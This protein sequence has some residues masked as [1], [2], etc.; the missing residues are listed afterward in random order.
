MSFNIRTLAAAAFALASRAGIGANVGQTFTPDQR[1][2]I[3]KTCRVP[4]QQSAA[5]AG[6][7]AE[8][9]EAGAGG[10]REASRRDQGA[11]RD[12]L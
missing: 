1:G 9:R 12:H 7:M 10:C 11:R 5:V 2:E 4:A 8:S 3:E 6:G